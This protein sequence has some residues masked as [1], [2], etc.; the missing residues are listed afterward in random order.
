MWWF[1]LVCAN[2]AAPPS[3]NLLREILLITGT[4]SHATILV[5]PLALISFFTAAYSLYLFSAINH[6]W[7]R[8]LSNPYTGIRTHYHLLI[9]LHIVP[10]VGIIISADII[11]NWL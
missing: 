6:G 8:S 7:V 3:I 10:V 9:I 4:L 11:T 1:L 5:V 2:I